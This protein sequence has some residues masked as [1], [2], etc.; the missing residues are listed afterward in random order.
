[1]NE[2]CNIINCDIYHAINKI[3]SRYASVFLFS[4][5]TGEKQF[6]E[7]AQEF[8]FISHAQVNRT[9]KEL[10]ASGLVTNKNAKYQLLTSGQELIPILLELEKW[11]NKYSI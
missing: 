1:M 9:L 11:N 7:L 8:D 10:I 6:N 4:L 5:S 2:S 3:K